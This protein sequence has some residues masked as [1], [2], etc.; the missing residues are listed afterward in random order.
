MRHLT[1]T[2]R[3][4]LD[5]EHTVAQATSD[6]VR[7]LANSDTAAL[8]HLI[9]QAPITNAYVQSILDTGRR[10]GPIGG[11]AR[12][13]F[14][15]IFD[16]TEPNKLVAACWAGANIVPVTN[17]FE[18]G[19]YFG[20]ALVALD[21]NFGSIFG[22]QPAVEGV[23]EAL[24]HGRQTARDIRKNQPF[25]T[26]TE[27]AGIVPNPHVRLATEADYGRVLP[28]SVAMF[29]EE[30]GYSPLA[31]GSNGYRLRVRQLIAKGHTMIDHGPED[32]VFKADFGIV[33]NAGGPAVLLAD[34]C[35]VS[36]LMRAHPETADV[37]V[38]VPDAW[39]DV[40]T[41]AWDSQDPI[42]SALAVAPVIPSPE[43]TSDPPAMVA[44]HRPLRCRSTDTLLSP[45][46]A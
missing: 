44:N 16:H 33:T 45:S 46:E 21:E 20:Q 43:M 36:E 32:V 42:G 2:L 27:Q 18:S 19:V 3:W 15:G 1:R 24:R 40:G 29:T 4:L 7:I 22:P 17:D 35:E 12:G 26:I 38:A 39:L 23:W 25:M 9:G 31:D 30:L 41:G 6:T 14:L 13:V 34:A 28:A 5:A 10:A 8:S 37:V 11:F